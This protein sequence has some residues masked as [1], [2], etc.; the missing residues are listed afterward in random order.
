MLIDGRIQGT[1]ADSPRAI[2]GRLYSSSGS[3]AGQCVCFGV[4]AP[5][6]LRKGRTSMTH[7]RRGAAHCQIPLPMFDFETIYVSYSIFR[8]VF[9]FYQISRR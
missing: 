5:S 8:F 3:H 2:R 9:K 4:H 6:R 7:R 1:S